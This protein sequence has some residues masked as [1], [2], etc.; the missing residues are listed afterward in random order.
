MRPSGRLPSHFP[1]YKTGFV[2]AVSFTE[3]V[4]VN[5][6]DGFAVK[7]GVLA[8]LSAFSFA[9]EFFQR[10]SGVSAGDK[11][12]RR[13]EPSFDEVTVD[14]EGVW[15]KTRRFQMEP[16]ARSEL[17]FFRKWLPLYE[18]IALVLGER[19][20]I[21]Y[22]WQDSANATRSE[23]TRSYTNGWLITRAQKIQRRADYMECVI[24]A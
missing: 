3:F 6:G 11:K 12:T 22:G 4:D 5:V 19:A 7:L 13:S 8:R 24:I 21:G 2:A 14:I 15:S 9:S 18:E 20:A 10:V 16:G 23:E 17:R 1:F